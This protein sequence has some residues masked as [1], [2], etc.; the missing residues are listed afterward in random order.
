MQLERKLALLALTL[1][2][3]G[4]FP[5]AFAYRVDMRSK[6]GLDKN[7]QAAIAR[8][9]P[10]EQ[11]TPQTSQEGQLG[12]AAKAASPMAA[13]SSTGSPFT[14]NPDAVEPTNNNFLRHFLDGLKYLL[15]KASGVKANPF[16]KFA[17]ESAANNAAKDFA[18]LR[19]NSP[20]D[21]GDMAASFWFTLMT[22]VGC[23][24]AFVLLL[25]RYPQVYAH[26]TLP[27]FPE[28][29]EE[30]PRAEPRHLFSWMTA[31]RSVEEDVGIKVAG[32]DGWMLL[33]YHKLGISILSYLAPVVC[34]ILAPMHY[35]M[36][37]TIF[38]NPFTEKAEEMDWF[39]RLGIKSMTATWSLYN[40]KFTISSQD[41][42]Y[43]IILCWA[44][45]LLVCFVVHLVTTKVFESHERFLKWRFRWLKEMPPPRSTTLL[46]ESIPRQLC[47]DAKMVAYFGK[48]FTKEAVQS[49]YVIRHTWALRHRIARVEELEAQV[50][51]AKEFEASGESVGLLSSLISGRR[52]SAAMLIVKLDEA[53]LA[54]RTERARA[55]AAAEQGD[56]K[57]C[58][59]SGFV[60]FTSRRF[61]RLAEQV[62]PNAD[63]SKL[64]MSLPPDPADIRYDD[65]QRPA[66]E[67]VLSKTMDLGLTF[68]LFCFWVPITVGLTSM[69]SLSTLKEYE[70]MRWLAKILERNP[71]LEHWVGGVLST[72]ALQVVMAF[73]PQ[74]LISIIDY[75]HVLKSGNAAQLWMQNRYYIFLVIFIVLVSAIS[76]T[77]IDTMIMI[78]QDPSQILVQLTQL[79]LTS[80]FYI[81]YI[82]VAYF[83]L[84]MA[85]L[86]TAPLVK[87]N[88]NRLFGST[89]LEAHEASEPENQAADGLG[90][91]M[92]KA[93]QF[94]TIA[95]TFCSA[96]PAISIIGLLYFLLGSR[97]YTWLVL[98]AETKKPDLG[99]EFWQLG[100]SHVFVAAGIYALMMFGVLSNA[101]YTQGGPSA[102]VF[103][104]LI[105]LFARWL[106]FKEIHWD[107]LPFEEV[108]EC[109]KQ[110][111]IKREQ[112]TDS[113][114]KV[115]KPSAQY[116]QPELLVDVSKE[117]KDGGSGVSQQQGEQAQ[118]QQQEPM[119]Q[120][121]EEQASEQD[122]AA[123]AE[124]AA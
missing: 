109:D 113:V 67:Q 49:A 122:V 92:A 7:Q 54:L 101:R 56:P 105:V 94:I 79:P 65:L 63:T 85:L 41:A 117:G 39:S 99:G 30:L 82:M 46:V 43:N 71:T 76:K 44:H 25:G 29:C 106:K 123:V 22:V 52:V 36:G 88:M 75:F 90:S 60:T 72:L 93:A 26:R 110:D 66:G 2:G 119:K 91:R 74:I 51:E 38:F 102:L 111:V 89:E 69:T 48:L 53:K 83:T 34:F 1:Y 20:E 116:I 3:G 118:Q 97:V 42:T 73:L 77:L 124:P 98:Y 108:V 6:L 112:A 37:T 19:Y 8:T 68:L 35:F 58:S 12:T 33:E 100:L 32:L 28:S 61:C 27:D 78:T 107:K 16:K 4:F 5:G 21:I 13:S 121:E 18:G 114:D 15:T 80:N 50:K 62:K 64:R 24:G 14:W 120:P 96:S 87:Y 57:V 70:S 115:I 9:L 40:R 10:P 104:A 17:E 55:D 81:S 11:P 86:R 95:L 84:A 23:L 47:S 31:S 59:T 103:A 45:A